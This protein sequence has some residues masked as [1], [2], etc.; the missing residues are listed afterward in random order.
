[1]SDTTDAPIDAVVAMVLA[2]GAAA[3]TLEPWSCLGLPP[4]AGR[5][6]SRKRYLQL[7][8]RLHP[9]KCVHARADEAFKRVEAAW[10]T[11]EAR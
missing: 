8:L 11:I 4:S 6:H 1:M 2:G 7:V 9:D 10:R 3:P 5:E